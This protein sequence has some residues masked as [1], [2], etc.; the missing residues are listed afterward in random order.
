MKSKISILIASV[1]VIVLFLPV[2]NCSD[3]EKGQDKDEPLVDLRLKNTNT[4]ASMANLKN[5]GTAI[6]SYIT[7]EGKAPEGDSLAAI[8]DKLQPFHIRILPL[9]D[10]YGNDI[11][12][13]HDGG[14]N[15]FLAATGL[16]GKFDGWDQ[17]T[18]GTDYLLESEA[19]YNKD[20][21][22]SNGMFIYAPRIK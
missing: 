20:I 14:E 2:V 12:Y 3:G 13:K 1:L 4:R 11:L 22:Y 9:K 17:D 18:G 21:I 19:D 5:I 16:D 6:E 8:K 10:G 7:D 15:Y